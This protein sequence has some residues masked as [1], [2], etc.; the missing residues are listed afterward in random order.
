MKRWKA[1]LATLAA[2]AV[3]STAAWALPADQDHD[4]RGDQR[5]QYGWQNQDHDR[6]DG[7][8]DRDRDRDRDGNRNRGR[9]QNRRNDGDRDDNG[10]Y[11]RNGPYGRYGNGGYYGNNG[12]Y[13][14]GPYGRYGNYGY[15]GNGNYGPRNQSN[16]LDQASRT[17]Y[18]DGINDGQNDR[19]TGHSFRPTHDDNYKHA[20]R[21]YNVAF[22]DKGT[23]QQAYRSGYEQGYQ[24]GYGSY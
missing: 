14:N 7:D 18:Q 6:R 24:A 3:L 19:R 9:W 21:G 23:Y 16:Y 8:H 15:Y 13:G 1:A 17:G 10:G 22:A 20:D 4:N 11:Y 2:G 12:Y 5:N